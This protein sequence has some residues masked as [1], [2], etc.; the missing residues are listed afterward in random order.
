M[1]Q[2]IVVNRCFGGFGLSEAAYSFMGWKWDGFGFGDDIKRDDPKLV[3]CVEKLKN[4]AN[5]SCAELEVVEI[6]DGVVWEI[7]EYDG[8]ETIREKHRSW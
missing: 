6:P 8:V 4:K 5:G 7:D 3:E 2:K 1:S